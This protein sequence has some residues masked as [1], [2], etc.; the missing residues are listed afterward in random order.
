LKACGVIEACSPR[1]PIYSGKLIARAVELYLNGV[2]PGYIRWT[3]L[4]NTLAKEF[5]QELSS[6]G[7]ELPSPETVIAWARKYPDAPQRLRK[8]RVQQAAPNQSVSRV[9]ACST[10]YQPHPSLPVSNAGIISWDINA[11]FA[12]FVA[13]VAVAT[14]ARC[15]SSCIA[16]V[17]RA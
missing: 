17:F 9:P 4:Q 1:G 2:K 5:P 7:R 6:S 11:L 13:V 12:Q 14:M 3:E 8:L 16:D 15:V 10:T